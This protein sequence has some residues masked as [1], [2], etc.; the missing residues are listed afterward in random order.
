MSWRENH[1]KSWNIYRKPWFFTSIDGDDLGF[2]G[3]CLPWTGWAL[4]D[5]HK[6]RTVPDS[7]FRMVKYSGITIFHRQINYVEMYR[8]VPFSI[9]ILNCQRLTKSMCGS[10]EIRKYWSPICACAIVHGRA[11]STW[12]VNRWSLEQLWLLTL[13]HHHHHLQHIWLLKFRLVSGWWFQSL[14]KIWKSWKNKINV[15]NHQPGFVRTKV[16]KVPSGVI[17]SM[18]CWKFSLRVRWF[19][20]ESYV[21]TSGYP[22]TCFQSG[23]RKSHHSLMP[24]IQTWI[25]IY[26][27]IICIYI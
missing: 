7:H 12:P 27:I 14:W 24:I 16:T 26:I 15:P 20:E 5:Q 2:F 23:E 1:G 21:D 13:L 6:T 19:S 17:S 8:N 3:E 18:V 11:D 10:P 22:Y 25:Y 4:G 9:A